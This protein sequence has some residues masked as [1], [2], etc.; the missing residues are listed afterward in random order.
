MALPTKSLYYGKPDG[1]KMADKPDE[2]TCPRDDFD[3]LVE[4]W[5]F[6]PNY[7]DDDIFTVFT[8]GT[9]HE[10]FPLMFCNGDIR[11]NQIAKELE[12]DVVYRGLRTGQSG[13]NAAQIIT[14]RKP[15]ILSIDRYNETLSGDSLSSYTYDDGGNA[16]VATGPH[17]CL[18][19]HISCTRAYLAAEKPDTSI[20][21]FS[22]QDYEALNT[23]LGV[24][25][26][27]P[28]DLPVVPENPWYGA[29]YFRYVYPYRWVLQRRAIVDNVLGS[30][31]WKVQDEWV[32]YYRVVPD[33]KTS[34]G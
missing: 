19:P 26:L 4:H 11:F 34:N 29:N 14:A 32:H 7:E 25:E 28:T 5:C 3:T 20:W 2:W 22:N 16:S 13:G 1:F 31:M 15:A 12:I 18:L 8:A 33:I 10:N 23:N 21:D 6:P 30:D 9:A 17:Q 24:Q 27:L